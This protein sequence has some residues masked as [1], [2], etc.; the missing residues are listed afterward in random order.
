MKRKGFMKID[1]L[2][3][4]RAAPVGARSCALVR[5]RFPGWRAR[6]RARVLLSR[7]ANLYETLGVRT[8]GL[9]V[10][11]G[12]AGCAAAP[13]PAGSRAEQE[14]ACAAAVAGHVA[15]PVEAVSASWSRAGADGHAIVEVRDGD[16]LHTCE[17]D[18]DLRVY[19][20]MHPQAE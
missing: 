11:V 20:L 13:D 1:Y 19:A 4:G 3:A 16:R 8:G 5:A 18:D 12:V 15:L 2:C 17:V 6:V 7:L 14:R 10:A 9:A